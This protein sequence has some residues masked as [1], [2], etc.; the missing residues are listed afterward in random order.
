MRGALW[1]RVAAGLLVAVVSSGTGAP[2]AAAAAEGSRDRTWFDLGIAPRQ[3]WDANFGYCGETSLISAGMSFGQYTSQWTARSLATDG[4]PQTSRSSQLL[5]GVN[6]L[7][8]AA[9]MR[10]RAVAYEGGPQDS[11]RAYLGWV[12]S[13]VM[14]GYPVIIGMYMNMSGQSGSPSSGDDEYD[15]IVPVLGVRTGDGTGARRAY[16][17]TDLLAFSDNSSPDARAVHRLPI[18]TL[19][20]TRQQANDPAAPDYSIRSRPRNYATAILGVMDPDRITLPVRLTSDL[21]VEG[22]DGGVD[23]MAD[24]PAPVP[25]NITATVLIADQSR[26]YRVYAYDDFAK[27]PVKDF[28]EHAADATASWTIPAHSGPTWSTTVPITSDQTLVF[29]AVPADGLR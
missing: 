21:A 13:K 23:R 19:L 1:L 9:A 27:V 24:P 20:R 29:R 12:E 26:A 3:Q 11:T 7:A 18:G 25:I 16:R 5:L 15:H 22:S 14:D 28:N 17:P 8:A 4:V 6:D 10:L 2:S